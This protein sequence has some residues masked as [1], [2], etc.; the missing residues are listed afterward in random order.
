M[1]NVLIAIVI[2]VAIQ[3]VFLLCVW[4]GNGPKLWKDG[5]KKHGG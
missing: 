5:G 3:L 4:I 2:F 1:S